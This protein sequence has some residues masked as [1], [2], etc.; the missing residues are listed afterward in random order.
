MFYM[1]L[2]LEK[3]FNFCWQITR[4]KDIVVAIATR[5]YSI[6]FFFGAGGGMGV[7]KLFVFQSHRK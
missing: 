4:T 5:F 1:K 3:S 7:I 2:D 6:Y